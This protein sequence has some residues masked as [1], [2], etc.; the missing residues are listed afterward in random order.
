MAIQIPDI[1]DALRP[2]NDLFKAYAL[3][4]PAWAAFFKSF[5]ESRELRKKEKEERKKEQIQQHEREFQEQVRKH[6]IAAQ[7]YDTLNRLVEEDQLPYEQYRAAVED[8]NRNLPPWAPKFVPMQKTEAQFARDISAILNKLPQP[9]TPAEWDNWLRGEIG[10]VAA[11]HGKTTE[12]AL[13]KLEQ[14]AGRNLSDL[15][16]NA[17]TK[18]GTMAKVAD[19]ADLASKSGAMVEPAAR[20][21]E[22]LVPSGGETVRR[23]AAEAAERAAREK[24]EEAQAAFVKQWAGVLSD[25]PA[26]LANAQAVWA[27]QFPNEPFPALLASTAGAAKTAYARQAAEDAFKLLRNNL[28]NAYEL[29]VLSGQKSRDAF[30]K[31][32]AQSITE[33]KRLG[34]Q[35]GLGNAVTI[36]TLFPKV[37]PIT[38]VK[39][40][41]GGGRSSGGGGGGSG[42]S[43]TPVI[44][45][46]EGFTIGTRVPATQLPKVFAGVKPSEL[47]VFRSDVG[48]DLMKKLGISSEQ[49]GKNYGKLIDLLYNPRRRVGYSPDEP[50]I[51]ISKA[52]KEAAALEDLNDSGTTEFVRLMNYKVF[53]PKLKATMPIS[54]ADPQIKK[55]LTGAAMQYA[56]DPAAERGK[57]GGEVVAKW[58]RAVFAPIKNQ[59]DR[60]NKASIEKI[61]RHY[62]NVYYWAPYEKVRKIAEKAREEAKRRVGKK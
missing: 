49:A 61:V 35:L 20:L 12:E 62:M 3:M 33:L 58:L 24:A 23:T 10:L 57:V 8:L 13:Q 28:V 15:V 34:A 45:L 1:T 29:Q 52:P 9:I 41:G 26:Q 25:D 42:G 53:D 31:D 14:I 4:E 44:D 21:A 6:N 7:Q 27:A 36:E 39:G 17:A 60:F 38:A 46:G 51:K 37:V 16:S 11:R 55:I 47:A 19:L 5:L 50:R 30:I 22:E 18:L 56:K 48:V 40:G 59:N 43:R 2:P 54:K 32:Y